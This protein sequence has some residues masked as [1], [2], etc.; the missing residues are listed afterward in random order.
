MWPSDCAAGDETD[1]V[2][3]KGL[4]A[5]RLYELAEL[6]CREQLARPEIDITTR[7]GL[8]IELM[9]VYSQNAGELSAADRP[10]IWQQANDAAE[11]FKSQYAT[12]SRSLLVHTQQGLMLISQAELSRQEA[13]I[14]A[15]PS[16]AF[17]A[18]LG[19]V[20]A[21]IPQLES[22][23]KSIDA[24]VRD[25]E[26]RSDSHGLSPQELLSLQNHVRYQIAR[27]LRCRGLCFPPES[28]DRVAAIS[29]AL[30]R[31][32]KPL[33]MLAHDDPLVL[34]IR[35]DQAEYQRLLGA[36]PRA[37]Q[38]VTLLRQKNMPQQV[39]WLALVEAIRLEIANRQP[40]RALALIPPAEVRMKAPAE[41]DLA[42]L[43]TMV[44]LWRQ[45]NAEGNAPVEKQWQDRALSQVRYMDQ[46][47]G[48]YWGRRG[49]QILV[50]FAAN[51]SGGPN[52]GNAELLALTADDLYRKQRLDEAIDAY[53]KAASAAQAANDLDQT[54]ILYGRAAKIE[55]LRS[56]FVRSSERW[57]QLALRMPTYA[58]ASQ[59]HLMAVTDMVKVVRGDSSKADAY[60]ALMDE[61][62]AH[63]PRDPTAD[64]IRMWLGQAQ[65]SRLQWAQAIA[66]YQAVATN[67]PHL[68]QA[69]AAVYRNW[70]RYLNQQRD[71]GRDISKVSEQAARYFRALVLDSD[72]KLPRQWTKT[73]RIAAEAFARLQ[74]MYL[75]T[76]FADVETILS[77]ALQNSPQA[78]PDWIASARMLLVVALA[79][80]PTRQTDARQILRQIG[81]QGG[82]PT[83]LIDL[84]D[85]LSELRKAA[86]DNMQL[87]LA[88]LQLDAVTIVLP[89]RSRLASEDQLRLDRAHASS[90]SASG[91]RRQAMQLYDK[92]C[93]DYTK[94][95]E[96]QEEYAQFLL[97]G[98]DRESLQLALDRWR[99]VARGRKPNTDSWYRAKYH[100][101]S[102]RYRLN[103][104]EDVVKFIE[105]LFITSPGV[106]QSEWGPKMERLL[107]LCK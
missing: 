14:S 60:I 98:N 68:E 57:R 103:E 78:D 28:D 36:L 33:T 48:P 11:Q 4:R 64:Q 102:A 25:A 92:L 106:K 51:N 43:E 96:L 37:Q 82:D 77:A 55:Q 84:I 44:A 23:E 90:L 50:G 29:E 97:A 10:A 18:A 54:F 46:S 59:A 12:H 34:Q 27:G 69:V 19:L 9:Q 7:A 74:L 3:L 20:R 16:A 65:E 5:R 94:N 66:A 15:N 49:Q 1:N 67:S 24:A 61:H 81:A 58:R 73:H 45:A 71:L 26:R 80:Q 85:K 93:K 89:T 42:V 83:Q 91:Q 41:L 79:N 2:F 47:H 8:T 70:L 21:A 6:Y 40:Q 38:I 105:Y 104:K 101:A 63:W 22:V 30:N 13:E 87:G 32:Q 31:L 17:N 76:G 100:V 52:S 95:G 72:Q 86:P 107:Q 75:N 56:R 53:E 88:N 35:L 39:Q 99:R 62:I